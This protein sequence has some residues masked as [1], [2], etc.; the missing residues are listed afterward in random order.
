MPHRDER[1]PQGLVHSRAVH[2]EERARRRQRDEVQLILH[3]EEERAFGT[4]E[5]SAEVKR[6]LAPAVEDLVETGGVHEG[7]EGVAGVAASDL[8]SR[9]GIAD[10]PAVGR[11]AEQIMDLAVDPRLERVGP[12]DLLRELFRR[13]RAERHL[14]AIGEKPSRADQVVAGRSVGDGV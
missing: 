4:G 11:I 9:I 10:E 14:G 6:P 5:E 2:H 12:R 3:A 1:G 13:E 8:G 7:V